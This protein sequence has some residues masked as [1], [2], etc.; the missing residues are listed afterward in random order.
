M[1]PKRYSVTV[2]T[3]ASG[4]ASATLP[5]SGEVGGRVGK[6]HSLIYTKPGSGGY[7]NNVVISVVTETTGVT[8]WSETL[9]TN[10][11]KVRYPSAPVHDSTG[12]ETSSDDYIALASEGVTV[13]ISAGGDT[14]SG[15]FTLVVLEP[16]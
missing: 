2:T 5:S 13:T 15:T 9:A 14:L 6:I 4:D 3:D 7:D 16:G 11:S 1:I 10:A 8:V 12:A